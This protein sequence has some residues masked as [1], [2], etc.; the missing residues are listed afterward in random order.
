MK[1]FKAYFKILK[2]MYPTIA[3]YVIVFL[4]IAMAFTLSNTNSSDP[5]F[6]ASKPNIA[7]FTND[8]DTKLVIGFKEYLRDKATIIDI[9]NDEDT[10]ND[11]LFY[12]KVTTIVTV[13]KDFTSQFLS[14]K[15]VKI[16]MKKGRDSA[17]VVYA[18]MLVNRYLN[19][20]HLYQSSGISEDVLVEKIKTDLKEETTIDI[21]EN[22]TTS[23]NLEKANFYY[24]YTNYIFLAI[25]ILVVGMIMQT[26]RAEDI[27]KRNLCAPIKRE[28]VNFELILGN[29]CTTFVIWLIFVMGSIILYGKAMFTINGWLLMANSFIFIISALAVAFLIGI[30]VKSNEAHSALA[31]VISLGTSFICGAFVP[32]MFLSKE[33]LS[34]G[35]LL[36]SYWFIR[37]NN[38]ISTST[39]NSTNLNN[40]ITCMVIELL[41]AIA[42]YTI[43]L[44]MSKAKKHAI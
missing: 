25:L 3:I 26:F 44:I 39:I 29:M 1:V 28:R 41:W 19:T 11:A 8:S 5:N 42:I 38:I 15:D 30:L 32:Q 12:E 33:V 34:V 16:D 36:S 2:K 43:T 22:K 10:I 14:G 17:S 21:I 7:I 4:A 18:N 35:Q 13:P 23:S 27:Y 6:I 37:A 31:N 24:N 40:I 9:K 20:A